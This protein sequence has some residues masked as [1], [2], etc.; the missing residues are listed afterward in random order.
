MAACYKI[1]SKYELL[2]RTCI[3]EKKVEMKQSIINS[4]PTTVINLKQRNQYWEQGYLAFPGLIGDDWLIPLREA[5]NE[6]IDQTKDY[7]KSTR[8]VDIEPDHNRDNP[9]LRRVTYLDDI[10]S[11]F[12][13]LCSESILPDLA[14]DVLG[15]NIRFRE[16]MLNFKWADGGA[17]VKW[18]QDLAFYPHTCSGTVQ[19]LLLLEGAKAD[20][21]PLQVIPG[22][23]K[24]RIF[25]HYDNEGNWT[26]C[27]ADA[28]LDSVELENAVSI[29]GPPG[30]VSIHHSL[31]IHGSALNTSPASRPAFVVTYSAADAMPYTAPAY[32]SSHYREL[33]R[34][35]QPKY[36]HHEE[37]AMPLPPDWSDGY[38]SIFEHQEKLADSMTV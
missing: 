19:I 10:D 11:I 25:R 38:T 32:P 15:P 29:T 18:H 36:A 14:A 28:D 22:S 17:E 9:R 6:V 26:G 7:K 8:K 31:M 21:G 24:G 27:I 37:M 5:V 2:T 35:H 12:W 20:Q 3:S 33:V 30:S 16:I 34:G 1:K 4:F 23:H 13:R